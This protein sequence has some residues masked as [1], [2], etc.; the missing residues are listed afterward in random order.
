MTDDMTPV[1]QAPPPAPA[2]PVPAAPAAPGGMPPAAPVAPRRNAGAV[3]WGIVLIG[4][5][6][7]LLVNQFVPGVQL[8][9]YWPVIVIA[10]GI[11]GMFGSATGHWSLKVA[12]EGLVVVAIGLVLLGQSLGYLAW[13]VWFNIF[14]L[15]PVLIVSL[16]LEIIGSG[17]KADWLRALSSLVVVAALAYGA[18]V[19]SSGSGWPPVFFTGGGDSEPFS[20]STAH[21]PDVTEGTALVKA[22]VSEFGLVGGDDLASADGRS[23][24]ELQY[25]VDSDGRTA[26]VKIGLE[27]S[28]V[29]FT[30]DSTLDVALDR[31]VAWDLDVKTGVSSFDVD[32]S[33]LALSSL[34]FEAGVSE[35]TLTL[36][37]SRDSADDGAI[38]ATIEG[39][40]STL[41]V[42]VPRGD[43]VR[44]AVQRGL[45]TLDFDGDWD[46]TDDGDRRVYESDGFSDN[47][48][49][50]DIELDGGVGTIT[51]EY[52]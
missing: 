14:R 2:E 8:L 26:D 23:S 39:G 30:S 49:Y 3:W 50:W 47:G 13:D 52:Y 46:R 16:G 32:L 12:A 29:G 44:V 5:G 15:W 42:R 41:T 19:M 20:M 51:V 4:I 48:S 25:D 9:Q 35:G 40:V 10:V 45:T 17:M 1:D 6:A 38:E 11:R 34:T 28:N 31:E 24:L 18:L 33:G 22:G 43:D 7:V 37:E 21:D 36:G 27:G